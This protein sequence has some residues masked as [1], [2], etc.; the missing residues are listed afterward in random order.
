M[1]LA[2]MYGASISDDF[3]RLTHFVIPKDISSE[4]L[5]AYKIKVNAKIVSTEWLKMCFHDKR[6]VNESE[7]LM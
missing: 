6:L 4:D 7:Y 1:L 2:K 5:E 3:S